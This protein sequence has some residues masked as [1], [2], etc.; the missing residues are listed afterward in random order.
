MCFPLFIYH[1]VSGPVQVNQDIFEMFFFFHTNS[2]VKE[3]FFFAN[4]TMLLGPYVG[5]SMAGLRSQNSTC[6][7]FKVF[8]V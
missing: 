4:H 7:A 5:F 3:V 8:F 6:N 2:R 1:N